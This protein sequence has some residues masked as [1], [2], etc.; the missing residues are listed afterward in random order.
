MSRIRSA[1]Q[2][3]QDQCDWHN[4]ELT[5]LKDILQKMEDFSETEKNMF[6]SIQ[7]GNEQAQYFMGT[8]E[9]SG[10]LITSNFRV[11][12]SGMGAKIG[13]RVMETKR[14][15]GYGKVASKGAQTEEEAEIA[16][17]PIYGKWTKELTLSPS[18]AITCRL[19]TKKLKS[20]NNG[21]VTS[22]S[23]S[24]DRRVHQEN[25][26]AY[27]GKQEARARPEVVLMGLAEGSSYA[28]VLKDLKS[29]VKPNTLR[30]KIKGVR[31]TYQD[32]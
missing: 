32:T 2:D 17:A 12:E 9:R 8:L 19:K 4:S 14:K 1:K 30:V 13:R 23:T 11:L 20:C 15:E 16:L 6:L 10:A 5:R 25:Q 28:K 31:K 21:P 18:K 3:F 7:G 26:E 24:E 22:T 27:E 29:E